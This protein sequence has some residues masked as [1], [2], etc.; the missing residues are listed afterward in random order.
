MTDK[1]YF[2]G[3]EEPT[4]V[5]W[6]KGG[7]A[8]EERLDLPPSVVAEKIIGLDC[9]DFKSRECP[10]DSKHLGQHWDF[11]Q[12]YPPHD[13]QNGKQLQILYDYSED[14]FYVVVWFDDL[15]AN[16]ADAYLT[17]YPK[18]QPLHPDPEWAFVYTLQAV[19]SQLGEAFARQ[20]V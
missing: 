13:L 14:Y 4:Q 16:S 18:K 7:M 3:A 20:A 9:P 11:Q 12:T 1:L 15:V 17:R 5:T 8:G 10:H 2:I 6:V 19:G